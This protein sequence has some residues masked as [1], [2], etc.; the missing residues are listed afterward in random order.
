[1]SLASRTRKADKLRE[2][3]AIEQAY[4]LAKLESSPE[5]LADHTQAILEYIGL[6]FK[7]CYRVDWTPTVSRWKAPDLGYNGFSHNDRVRTSYVQ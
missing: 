2:Q 3:A 6:E 4:Q 5:V 7:A 1:M